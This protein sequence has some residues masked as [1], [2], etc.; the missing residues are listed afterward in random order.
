MASEIGVIVCGALGKVGRTVVAAVEAEPDMHLAG[1]VDLDDDLLEALARGNVM[2]DFT[3]PNAAFDNAQAAI[4]AGVAPVVGT[5]GM[6]EDQVDQLA[7]SADRAQ[8]GGA[9]IP[10]FA[11]GAVLMMRLA[12]IAAPYFDAVEVIEAHHA[13]KLDAPSGTALST[14]RRLGAARR[15]PFAYSRPEKVTLDHTRGGEEG[16]VGVHSLRLPGL[17]ADQEILFGAQGQTLSIAHRT[18][19][20]EAFMPGVLA[21]VRA[22]LRQRRFFRSLDDV[23]GLP[24]LGAA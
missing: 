16:A 19:S 15:Q 9:V 2:V 11:I 3:A 20:R 8:T 21:T 12:E 13:T 14:A 22:V 23:L 24:P 5:T 17:V 10:N 6:S 18:T 4:A 7:A 1:A